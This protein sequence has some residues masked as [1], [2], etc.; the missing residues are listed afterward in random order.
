MG[1]AGGEFEGAEAV[2]VGVVGVDAGDG[3]G[4]VGVAFPAAAEVEG[5][6]DASDAVGARKADAHCIVLAVAESRGTGV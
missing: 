5:A 4:G 6:V 3:E 2:F 1:E